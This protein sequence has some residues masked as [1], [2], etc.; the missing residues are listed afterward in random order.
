MNTL[1]AKTCHGVIYNFNFFSHGWSHYFKLLS[2]TTL[3]K[4][5]GSDLQLLPRYRNSIWT[6][7]TEI[8]YCSNTKMFLRYTSFIVS[9]TENE[10]NFTQRNN[11]IW[12]K[13]G[14]WH[15]QG[16]EFQWP[17]KACYWNQVCFKDLNR[18]QGLFKTTTKIQDLFK[19]VRTMKLEKK[20]RILCYWTN[21]IKSVA[22]CQVIEPLTEKKK[23]WGWGWVDLL[24]TTKMA[25]H[26]TRFT[27]P[28]KTNFW[29]RT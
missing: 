4:M 9:Y 29:L 25:E 17:F 14:V 2:T 16:S 11:L 12:Q 21:D 10:P 23:T 13:T 20:K 8:K 22:K 15:W 1:L 3:C 24:G 7:E 18:I 6:K 28:K 27:R 5:T 26:F 19:I